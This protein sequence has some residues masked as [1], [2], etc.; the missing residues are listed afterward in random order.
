MA[1]TAKMIDSTGSL[2]GEFNLPEIVF[3]GKIKNHLIYEEVLMQLAGR[4]QGTAKTKA[5][6]EVRGGGKKPYRQKGTGHARQGTIR[7]PLMPGG[8]QTFG[9][10]PRVYEYRLPRKVRLS[11]LQSV[12][13]LKGGQ[14]KIFVFDELIKEPKTKPIVKLLDQ[15]K[16]KKA[17]FVAYQNQPLE[18]SVR[19]IKDTKYLE[20]SGINVFDLLKYEHLFISKDCVG[21]LEQRFAI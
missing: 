11:A 10:T 8:G 9:P 18:K 3:G 15:L 17:L 16:V 20:I 13:S 21:R 4:R 5:R 1:L 19:N 6:A 7:S 12:L 2:K 14:E